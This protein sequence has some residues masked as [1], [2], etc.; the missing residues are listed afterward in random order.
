MDVGAGMASWVMAYR[1]W[2]MG[3]LSGG[4][5]AWCVGWVWWRRRARRALRHR[6]TVELVP[7]VDFDPSKESIDWFAGQLERVP[8]AAGALPRRASAVR[9]RFACDGGRLAYRVEGP[10]RAASVLR[11]SAY[12]GVEV[13][14]SGL[15]REVPRVHFEGAAPLGQEEGA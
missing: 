14:D 10:A 12:S 1:W 3:G 5:G 15:S 8:A 4:A 7:S 2:L 9:L 11:L 13:V 6:V